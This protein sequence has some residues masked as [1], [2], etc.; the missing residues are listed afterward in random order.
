[1]VETDFDARPSRRI[2]IET[3]RIGSCARSIRWLARKT[4]VIASD[5]TGPIFA[6]VK[7]HQRRRP[8]IN[9]TYSQHVRIFSDTSHHDTRLSTSFAQSYRTMAAG[10]RLSV[11]VARS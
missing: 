10:T 3:K 6:G 8:E 1:M 11:S 4:G 9:S 7:N 5:R 2:T